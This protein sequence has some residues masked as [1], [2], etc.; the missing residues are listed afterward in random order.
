MTDRA[1]STLSA[2]MTSG[3]TSFTVVSAAKFAANQILTID[4][5]QIKVCSVVGT[6]VN[7]GHSSCPNID[8]R[9]FAGTSAASHANATTVSNFVTAYSFKAL[10]E[11]VKAIETALGVNLSTAVPNPLPVAKGGTG[12]QS[13]AAARTA[14]GTAASGANSDITSLSSLSTPLS[15]AQGGTAATTAAGARTALSA[16]ASGANSDITSLAS[17][18]TPLTVPQ[19]GTGA[20]TVTGI[21]QGNGTS[22]LTANAASA[23]LTYLRRKPNNGATVAY[24]FSAMPAVSVADYNFPTQTPGGSLFAGGAGQSITLTPCPLG[25]NGTDSGHNVYLS[26]GTGAAEATLITGGTC[27]SGAAT[28]TITVTPTNAHSGS[29]TIASATAGWQEAAQA[30]GAGKA[31]Y[32]P[33]G[34][35]S[36]RG[37][38]NAPYNGQTYFADAPTSVT[39]TQAN[40][41]NL[42]RL[43]ITSTKSDLT[44]LRLGWDGNFINQTYTAATLHDA[45]DGTNSIGLKVIGNRFHAFGYTTASEATYAQVISLYTATDCQ[46]RDNTFLSNFAYEVNMHTATGCAITGNTFGSPNLADAQTP[47]NWWDTYSGGFGTLSIGSTNIYF[48]NNR[49]FGVARAGTGATPDNYG[50]MISSGGGNIQASNLQV[51]NNTFQGLGN[52]RGTVAVTNASGTITG[53]TTAFSSLDV[54]RTFVVEGDTTLYKVTAYASA[55][56]IT[57]TPVVARANGSGLRYKYQN[58]GDAIAV[59]SIINLHIAGNAVYYSGDNGFDI[60]ATTGQQSHNVVF[61]NNIAAYSQV[62]GL[63]MGGSVFN[64]KISGNLFLSNA[65]R[66]LTDHQGAIELSPTDQGS[67]TAQSMWHI[68]FENNHFVDDTSGTASQI[69]GFQVEAGED[70]SILSNTLSGNT[71]YAVAGGF[72]MFDSNTT[73]TMQGTMFNQPRLNSVGQFTPVAFGDLGDINAGSPENGTYGYCF[74]CTVASGASN[75]CADSGT[76]ALYM[77]LNG[78]WRCFNAQN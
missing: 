50:Y 70:A 8:G 42:H 20:A 60:A 34:T 62:A 13:A 77:R 45:I 31:I 36:L 16:A 53:T 17:L 69:Y 29:W 40:A 57:V 26:G 63:Y 52:A 3:A 5:E 74:D 24:E 37:S 11:E 78:A 6:T 27:T 43:A 35:Y 65:R 59:Y 48:A 30:A 4:S 67:T 41:N 73:T 61:S 23:E 54:G 12:A 58:S 71:S 25:L 22:G 14:L 10:R 51:H 75:V 38:F 1:Q 46:I 49:T 72:S 19:G 56:G 66:G 33:P 28:G 2:S 55:T 44:F 47:T 39:I 9:G 68:T 21:L 7:V 64:A 18:S 32:F 15:V 76:G